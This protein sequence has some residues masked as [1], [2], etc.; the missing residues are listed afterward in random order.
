MVKDSDPLF[1]DCGFGVRV[2]N[3]TK[4]KRIRSTRE[5]TVHVLV[6]EINSCV[7]NVE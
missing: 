5:I 3:R 1:R 6:Q 4:Q 2:L 7:I